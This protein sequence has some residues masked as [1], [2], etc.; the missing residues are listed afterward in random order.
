MDEIRPTYQWDSTSLGSVPKSIIAFLEVTDYEGAVRNAVLL[1]GDC[2]LDRRGMVRRRTGKHCCRGADT[3][4]PR[5]ARCGEEIRS[6]VSGYCKVFVIDNSPPL[7]YDI[8]KV[9]RLR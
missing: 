9:K 7:V 3:V 2:R 8:F 4:E 6:G 5:T 1:G